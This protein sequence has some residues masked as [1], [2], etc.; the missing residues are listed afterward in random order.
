MNLQDILL[1]AQ[2]TDKPVAKVFI[3]N[4]GTK[5]LA[6]GLG[7]GVVLKTHKTAFVSKLIVLV[8]KVTYT[9]QNQQ[10][11]LNA[12]DSHDIPVQVLHELSAQELSIC[13]LVQSGTTS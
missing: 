3:N 12:L 13:L 11:E 9:E 10:I 2:S 1:E 8:G 5:V 4:Q 6:I 7:K